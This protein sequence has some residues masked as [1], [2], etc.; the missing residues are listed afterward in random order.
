MW[1]VQPAFPAT[2]IWITG[3]ANYLWC[4]L[5]ILCFLYQY[6]KLYRTRGEKKNDTV[7]HAVFLFFLGILTGWTNEN[8][9]ISLLLL[10][11]VFI[12]LIRKEVDNPPRWI[13]WG[14]IGFILGAIILFA[15]PGNYLRVAGETDNAGLIGALLQPEIFMER[16]TTIFT[17]YYQ[18]MLKFVIFYIVLFFFVKKRLRSQ[19]AKDVYLIS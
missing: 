9:S 8:M 12:Y 5:L 4:T 19:E 6:Y 16:I 15:A 7:I 2:A 14:M 3:S 11:A 17:Y 13:Y 18:F 10:I 1:F